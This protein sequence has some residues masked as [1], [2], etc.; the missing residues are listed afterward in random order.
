MHEGERGNGQAPIVIER[1]ADIFVIE[2]RRRAVHQ[3]PSRGHHNICEGLAP[4]MQEAQK[5][6]PKSVAP[7]KDRSNCDVKFL[8]LRRNSDQIAR[9][10]LL[11]RQPRHEQS[12]KSCLGTSIVCRAS[13]M[14]KMAPFTLMGSTCFA[15]RGHLPTSH[16]L[17]VPMPLRMT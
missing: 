3:C 16:Y 7:S 2:R 9:K 10:P 11:Y 5:R 15:E 17:L 12:R 6:D 14:E 8:L 13:A 4:L 1:D